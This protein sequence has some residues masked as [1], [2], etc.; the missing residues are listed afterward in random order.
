MVVRSDVS[1]RT[2]SKGQPRTD[3]LR[4]DAR[5]D[6]DDTALYLTEALSDL[7]DGAG[8]LDR[9]SPDAIKTVR[10][11]TTTRRFQP[12]ETIFLQGDRHNGIFL[13]EAGQVRTYYAG[14]SGREITLAY[15]TPGHFVGGPEVFGGGLHIWSADAVDACRLS[16][17]PGPAIRQLALSVPSFAICLIDGLVAKGKCYSALIHMLGT[18]SA[19]ERLAQLLL[20]L[21]KLHDREGSGNIVVGRRITHEKLAGIV[22]STRQWVTATLRRFQESGIIVVERGTIVIRDPAAL[23]AQT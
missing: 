14:P 7:N 17:L 19:T 4:A 15:W 23:R 1:T 8:F 13:I 20:I 9:L 2:L 12:G 11:A 16:F 22:G 10:R 3:V 5:P 18:R 6:R 21:A